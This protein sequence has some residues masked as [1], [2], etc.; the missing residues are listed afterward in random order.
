[1][2]EAGG[3]SSGLKGAA[4]RTALDDAGAQLDAAERKLA[5]VSASY[6][7]EVRS[8]RRGLCGRRPRASRRH[9]AR[10]FEKFQRD[11]RSPAEAYAAFLL[12]PGGEP[13]LVD[14]GAAKVID[15]AI[16]AWRKAVGATG[17]AD[18]AGESAKE[19]RARARR[20]RAPPRDL[21]SASHPRAG[22][23][24][25][26][27]RAGRG[28]P[29]GSVRGL[30]RAWPG[31]PAGDRPRVRLRLGRARPRRAGL[32]HRARLRP[33]AR[34]AVVRRTVVPSGIARTR[35][36]RHPLR[37][38][39]VLH[40]APLPHAA[41]EAG[42]VA[43]LVGGPSKVLT[44]AD[45]TESAFKKLAPGNAVVHLATHGFVLGDRCA[46][47]GQSPLRLTGLALAGANQPAAGPN[48]DDG[49]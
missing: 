4:L 1:V 29:P 3:G 37:H 18:V 23:R 30:A 42:D 41:R 49:F 47:F 16:D 2:D 11:S 26:D 8:P 12:P 9:L 33:G 43:K 38:R 27:R 5:D 6:R 35:Q 19:N 7:S 32:G 45:A 17:G 46:A 44:G 39:P 40:F 36:H 24:A 34:R 28:P 20:S 15:E 25:R 31:V 21:G 13:R 22:H 48:G 10:R 14:L